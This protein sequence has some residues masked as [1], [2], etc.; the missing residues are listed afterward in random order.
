LTSSARYHM[1]IDYELYENDLFYTI[2][3]SLY[4]STYM[5]SV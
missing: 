4:I 2:I 3:S 1:K 5:M